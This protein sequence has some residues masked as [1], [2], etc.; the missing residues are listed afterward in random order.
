SLFILL[1]AVALGTLTAIAPAT[2]HNWRVSREAVLI[3]ANTGINL[4]IGNHEGA[5]GFFTP[6]T[7]E[8]NGF[9]TSF[10]YPRIV[11]QLEERL[12]HRLTYTEVSNYF[13][14]KAVRFIFRRPKEFLRLS[15]KR[16][17]LLFGPEEIGHNREIRLDRMAS[18]L[19][20]WNPFDFPLALALASL[21]LATLVRGSHHHISLPAGLRPTRPVLNCLLAFTLL[22]LIYLMSFSV[23]FVT[24]LFRIPVVPL[25][26]VLG[27][28]GVVF[29][30]EFWRHGHRKRVAGWVVGFVL[31]Y[32]AAR[33][34]VIQCEPDKAKWHYDRGLASQ[35]LGRYELALS[36][37]EQV[38]KIIPD[39]AA[40][41]ANLGTLLAR[42]GRFEQAL[43]HFCFAFG[44]QAEN[45]F[46]R[47][48]YAVCLI[49][50]DRFAEALSVL[51]S[52]GRDHEDQRTMRLLGIC[53]AELGNHEEAVSSLRKA[54]AAEPQSLENTYNLQQAILLAGI[55]ETPTVAA[56]RRE[57][58]P[59]S[60]LTRHGF[61]I[62][63]D[64]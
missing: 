33:F 15:L 29:L 64:W 28:G 58:P 5:T 53:H 20:R 50:L 13:A 41:H 9:E 3:S 60:F 47:R 45:L 39:D 44:Q 42:Q 49:M 37:F 40:A 51:T 26:L 17:A 54:V 12:G 36:E 6:D 32:L 43:A 27:S 59:G 52:T 16:I 21:G 24:A 23:F 11:E 2:L 14:A 31:L 63:P 8:I 57:P 18:P 61:A 34:P 10:D 22:A 25:F 56:Q 19:L 55:M 35:L 7:P 4:H 48:G 1:T 30:R 46:V 62:P 38:L